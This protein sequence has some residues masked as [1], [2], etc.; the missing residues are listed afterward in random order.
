MRGRLQVETVVSGVLKG[1]PLA[2]PVRREVPVYLPPSYGKVRRRFPVLYYLP[3]FT[4]GGRT[5]VNFSH[6]KENMAERL[7]RLVAEGKA[8]E[9]V[10]IVPD[11]FTAYGGSQYV[12][13]AATGRY[14]DHVVSELVPYFEDKLGL[15]R[16]ADSRGVFGSSSGGFGALWLSSRHPEVFAHAACHCGDMLF[17]SCYALDFPKVVNAIDRHGGTPVSLLKAFRASKAKH[18]FDHAAVNMLAMAACYSPNP[19]SP[20]GFDLPFD[21]RTGELIPAVWRRWKAFDPVVFAPRR[22]AAFKRLKTLFIDAGTKDEFYLHQGARKLHAVLRK[23]GVPHLYEEHGLGHFDLAERF[24]R[25]LSL[26][27]RRLVAA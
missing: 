11:C 24:E 26:L 7:D 8:R 1:N 25:S 27:S 12:N 10:L 5:A 2:D 14:E 3:G 21:A 23:A 20:L 16:G 18:S 22:A 15:A 13:S 19:K 4:G 6:W 9:C 17:E